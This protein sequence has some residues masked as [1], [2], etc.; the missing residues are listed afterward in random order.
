MLVRYLLRWF[1]RHSS[2]AV[3]KAPEHKFIRVV[4]WEHVIG[5][6]NMIFDSHLTDLL[7]ARES[8]PLLEELFTAVEQQLSFCSN[9][10]ALVGYMQQLVQPRKV[11]TGQQ[12]TDYSIEILHI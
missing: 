6:L 10:Q 8:Q 5:W 1:R 11:P 12:S 7:L 3:Q 2:G 9:L 4:P